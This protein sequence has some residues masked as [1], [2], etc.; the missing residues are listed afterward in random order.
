MDKKWYDSCQFNIDYL[1]GVFQDY[2]SDVKD[3]INELSFFDDRL[4]FD[5]WVI[6]DNGLYNYSYSARLLGLNNFIIAW[7]PSFTSSTK[8]SQDC[9]NRGLFI[10]ISGKGLAFLQK[11]KNT[12]PSMI[13]FFYNN[14]FRCSRFDVNCDIFDRDNDIVPLLVDS[15]DNALIRKEGV[16]GLICDLKRT[17][18]NFRVIPIVDTD[19]NEKFYN[20]YIGHHGTN[21]G[22]FRCYNKKIEVKE[23]NSSDVA[24]II[25]DNV[26]NPSYWYRLEYE[27]HKENADK[28]FKAFAAGHISLREAFFA[29]ADRFFTPVIQP[30]IFNKN[31]SES[32]KSSDLWVSFMDYLSVFISS[33]SHNIEIFTHTPDIVKDTASYQG[34][35]EQMSTILYLAEQLKSAYPEWYDKVVFQEGKRKFEDKPKYFIVRS[36]LD[37]ILLNEV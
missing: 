5:N 23:M 25:L 30:S 33:N 4:R 26:G 32:C 1:N 24:S 31:Y 17:N 27:V 29:C 34:Y 12:L 35:C 18:Q 22:M 2:C 28:V 8:P 11:H 19:T 9:N 13:K 20:A 7:N 6:S 15:I 10:S 36:E 37:S 3:F 21:F 14:D 16:A